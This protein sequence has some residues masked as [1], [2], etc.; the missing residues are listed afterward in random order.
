MVEKISDKVLASTELS[1]FLLYYYS[2]I[3]YC[4]TTISTC[5]YLKQGS[6]ME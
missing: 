2:V 4:D 6:M 3:I 5:N 1:I